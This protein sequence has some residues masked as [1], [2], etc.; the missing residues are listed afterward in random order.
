V[1]VTP[2]VYGAGVQNKILEAMAVGLPVVSTSKALL[3][4]RATPGSEILIGDTPVELAAEILNL[5]DDRELRQ[6]VSGAGRAYVC[7][8]HN[9]DKISEQLS[10]I[11]RQLTPSDPPILA[12]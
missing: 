3:S 5:L 12:N 11:Y 8:N 9:W 2:L 1:A 6:R 10:A 4:L 7:E